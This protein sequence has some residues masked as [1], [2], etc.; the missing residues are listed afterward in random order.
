M[1]ASS[2]NK[3]ILHIC[4]NYKN[5][6]VT[7]HFIR[8]LAAQTSFKE[9]VHLVVANNSPNPKITIL[10]ELNRD[11]SFERLDFANNPGY[12]G[13]AQEVWLRCKNRGQHF[14]WVILS[15]TDLK[16]LSKDFYSQLL[17]SDLQRPNL[18]LLAPSIISGI[19]GRETNPFLWR[20][21][22]AYR[23]LFYRWV[24]ANVLT[25]QTYQMLGYLKD[26]IKNL[27]LKKTTAQDS[28]PSAQPI[29]APHGA[30]MI[31]NHSYFD[32][33][34]DFSH[35]CFLYGEEIAVAEK[36][37][38]N[39]LQILFAPSLKVFHD[40]HGSEGIAS[41]LFNTKTYRFKRDS[42]RAIYETYF[43][44]PSRGAPQ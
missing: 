33:G 3:K 1:V 15:N 11:I 35:P 31:F 42:S 5:D 13:A 36:C 30:F 37:R 18:G 2:I 21:P 6:A 20:R 40:E 43:R 17:G 23:M 39:N 19:S 44:S 24:F 16:M 14:D 41:F 8:E 32:Q 28:N 25:C 4:V 7:S 9:N 10:S 29:Y 26:R 34:N 12:F 27:V 22:S 38:K